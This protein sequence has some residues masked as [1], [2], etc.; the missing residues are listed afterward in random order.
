[1]K[2]K[3]FYNGFQIDLRKID[4]NSHPFVLNFLITITIASN[5]CTL[6]IISYISENYG[7]HLT[8]N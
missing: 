1:V 6:Y 7:R 2:I 8:L 3:G 5:F 4:L